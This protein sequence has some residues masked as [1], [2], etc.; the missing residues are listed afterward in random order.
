[1]DALLNMDMEKPLELTSPE[2]EA[3]AVQAGLQS[4]GTQRF[5][6]PDE[7]N[8]KTWKEMFKDL[9]WELEI[10]ITGE[11]R[12]TQAAMTTLSTLYASMVQNPNDQEA[13]KLVRNKILEITGVV[14]PI[15]IQQIQNVQQPPQTPPIGGA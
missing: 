13:S 7:I 6:K 9:A 12:D 11:Q 5:I 10:D 3:P 15:E 4:T 1:M 14:S 2:A 8:S